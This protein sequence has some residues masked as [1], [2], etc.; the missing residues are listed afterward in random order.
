MKSI[1]IQTIQ[2][3][4]PVLEQHRRLRALVQTLQVAW[5]A[6][7]LQFFFLAILV[8]FSLKSPLTP[9]YLYVG[10][11]SYA[12]F[13]I[14]PF[15]FVYHYRNRKNSIEALALEFDRANPHALDFF[16]TSL[17]LT[18]HPSA[19]VAILDRFYEKMISQIQI[20]KK[21][22]W[23]LLNAV[24]IF[25]GAS[26]F[27][28]FT[29]LSHQPKIFVLRSIMPLSVLKQ[30]PLLH[31]ELSVPRKVLGTGDSVMISGIV[32]NSV[33]GQKI[34]AYLEKGNQ[35][36]RYPFELNQNGS[37]EFNSGSVDQ[38][39]K[40]YF[41]GENGTSP[42]LKF[43]VIAPPFLSLLQ[44]ILIPPAYTHLKNDTLPSGMLNFSVYP[45]T[46]VTWKLQTSRPLKYLVL[47][48]SI[49]NGFDTIPALRLIS[50]KSPVLFL[51]S[52]SDT[53][54]DPG[55][56][57]KITKEI[58][59][60]VET[61]F[62]LVDQA[63]ISSRKEIPGRIEL[64]PDLF[65]EVEIVSPLE[66]KVVNRDALISFTLRAKDDFKVESLK[67][68][69]QVFLNEKVVKQGTEDCKAWLRNQQ[70]GIINADWD[71][72]SF[73]LVPENKLSV[74]FEVLDNDTVSGPKVGKSAIRNF[75]LASMQEVFAATRQSE[76]SAEAKIR[77]A[78]QHEKQLEKKIASE[79]TRTHEEGPQMLSEYD[80]NRIMVDEPQDHKR[81]LEATMAQIQQSFTPNNTM[82][83]SQTSELKSLQNQMKEF[84]AEIKK[85]DP[86]MPHGNQSFLPPEERK[87]NLDALMKN[88]KE[89][90]EKWVALQEKLDKAKA[91]VKDPR[92]EGAKM[93]ADDLAKDLQRNRENQNDLKKLLDEQASQAKAKSDM[94]DQAIEEQ[95]KSAQEMQSASNELKKNMD[96][97]A[98]NNLLSPELMEKMKKIDQLMHEVLPDSI[99][100][101]MQKKMAGQE[102]N[103]DELK[104]KLQEMLSKQ[105]ELAE[106]LNRALAMLEQLKDKKRLQE[107]KQSLNDLQ[108]RESNLEKSLANTEGAADQKKQQKSIEQDFQKAM[109]DFSAQAVHK[110]SLQ[111]A[112]K[113]MDR[114][115][116]EK[117]M[118]AVREALEKKSAKNSNSNATASEAAA[119]KAAAKS[120]NAAAASLGEMS[121]SL[122]ESMAAMENSIDPEEIGNLLQESLS[123]SRLQILIRSGASERKKSGWEKDETALYLNVA[124]TAQWLNDK[125]KI[126]G[127]KIPF[128]SSSMLTAS[129][130]LMT[131]TRDASRAFNGDIAEQAL[132]QN[133]NLSRELLKLL[134]MA[135]SGTGQGSGSGTGSSSGSG[136]G[137]GSSN[138]GGKGKGSGEGE[139]DGDLASQLQGMSGK[140]MAINQATY[141]LLQS[142]LQGR[143]S[144]GQQSGGQQGNAPQS[145]GSQSGAQ[146]GGGQQGSGQQGGSQNGKPAGESQ[147]GGGTLPGL[148]NQQGELGEK[149]ESLAEQIN[150]EGTGSQAVRALADQARAL[151]EE[152][153]QGRISPEEIQK[154]QNRFQTRLLEAASALQ[155]RGQSEKR[156]SETARNNPNL[157]NNSPANLN[158]TKMLQL[159]REARKNAKGLS[160]TQAERKHLDEYYET[161][162]TH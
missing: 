113:K 107:L 22:P 14:L 27:V 122:S 58:R 19:T 161:L 135:Q 106:S 93:R 102:I 81:R 9:S 62:T 162:L 13:L 23:T 136:S 157:T 52:K 82:S 45:G 147:T 21:R 131:T 80:V 33:M 63:G 3:L 145:G 83:P 71:I 118:E 123:L 75:R 56:E 139:G 125:I 91:S 60:S 98:K 88:Q 50:H 155:E 11:W 124:Q 116:A 10:A 77:S 55:I 26:L 32:Q 29:I 100:D 35:E 68:V 43:S 72:S 156:E 76:Q 127:A 132:K 2:N 67:L 53:L 6:V 140:Q 46:R 51:S 37:F 59:K 73:K 65:P 41:G 16:R 134:K 24:T 151:E 1:K 104:Q 121:Q 74:H 64:T 36:T 128:M 57:V 153:R 28:V 137:E 112:E 141:Q 44:P 61:Q 129:R 34:F 105:T 17:S 40:V 142:M 148:A 86:T 96:Q 110:K 109:S 126:L 79:N 89:E 54:K 42:V 39:F 48:T 4:K 101:L 111:A 49:L 87:K 85:M 25:C 149:L 114:T 47:N 7:A 31:F 66:D 97:S 103:E 158:E 15:V 130:N 78:L 117:H 38:D 8:W 70:A 150:A 160:L 120:A 108:K 20:P 69:Y 159:L 92:I 99:R 119:S 12:L 138:P 95:M 152:M 115:Q 143:Q 5:Y 146:Q 90:A 94:M 133:Q 144:G 18:N 84:S 30:L 154:K